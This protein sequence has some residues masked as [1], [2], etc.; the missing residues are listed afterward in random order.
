MLKPDQAKQVDAT[1]A[2]Q[3]AYLRRLLEPVRA[4]GVREP[5]CLLAW[6]EKTSWHVSGLRHHFGEWARGQSP[7]LYAQEAP[8][9]P[10]WAKAMEGDG[11]G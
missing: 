9:K 5:H 2:R 8:E 11:K 1:L 4:K 3:E 6:I 7:P 10:V